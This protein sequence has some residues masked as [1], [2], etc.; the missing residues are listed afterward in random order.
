VTHEHGGLLAFAH[1]VRDELS[2]AVQAQLLKWR[3][4]GAHSGQI[5]RD[6]TVPSLT[7]FGDELIPTPAP[8]GS[9][10]NENEHRHAADRLFVGKQREPKNLREFVE[11]LDS[12][13]IATL[14]VHQV[15][16]PI[17]EQ[18]QQHEPGLKFGSWLP[19]GE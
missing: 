10:V 13:R 9:P 12:R 8:M 3:S 14:D 16:K 4:V 11:H 2:P 15:K 6:H 17:H 7:E 5:R 1:Q 18:V 19:V